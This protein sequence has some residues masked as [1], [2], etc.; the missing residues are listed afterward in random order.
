MPA[1]FDMLLG[2]PLQAFSVTG[3]DP[4]V[5]I[6]DA[7]DELPADA[8]V[9]VLKLISDHFSKLPPFVRLFIT[10]REEERIKQ[11][12]DRFKPHELRVDEARN[13]Q[14]LLAYLAHVARDFVKTEMRSM[15]TNSDMSRAYALFDFVQVVSL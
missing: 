4:A 8:I 10:S 11:A 1:I 13:R 6:I 12:L 2:E 7:L 14:D 9:P 5:I 15:P 3:Q